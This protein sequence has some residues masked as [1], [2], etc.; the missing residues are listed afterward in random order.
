MSFGGVEVVNSARLDAYL[1]DPAQPPNLTT[2]TVCGCPTLTAALLGHGQYVAPEVDP[3]PWWDPDVPHSADF[4][5]LL[6]LSVDGLDT[7]PVTRTVTQGV[8]GRATLRRPRVQPRTITVTALVVAT[9]CCGVDYGLSW[10][11]EVLAGC[12][13]DGCDG[14][15]L[16][17]GSCCPPEGVTPEEFAT[18]YTRTVRRVGVTAGP[19]VVARSGD[20]CTSTPG[21]E[22]GADVVTVEFT[23]TAAVPWRW[24]TPEVVLD[25]PPPVDDTDDCVTWCVH[26]PGPGGPVGGCEGECPHAPC[27]QGQGCLDPSCYT[28]APPRAPQPLTCYCAPVAAV[29][30]VYEVDLSTR[31]EW[32]AAVPVI[33]VDAGSQDLRRVRVSFFPRRPEDEGV[34]CEEVAGA[35]RC[36]PVG[37]YHVGYLPAGARA[38]FDGTAGH[39][40]MDCDGTTTG[41]DVWG[42]DGGP[43]SWPL[44]GCGRWCVLVESDAFVPP[45]GDARVTVAVSGREL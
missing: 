38:V 43:V 8:T 20:G 30:E 4:L 32:G 23:V 31:P 11:G 45:A 26:P 10:L 40:Y 19:T 36:A 37:V 21:C 14:M 6:V 24:T 29:S 34:S 7:R 33:T 27:D 18:R 2:S 41:A 35:R 44:L 42:Q 1:A 3:A 16:V 28:P 17:I 22:A 15:D 12:D 13:Q 9:S 25:V 5:G 39:A